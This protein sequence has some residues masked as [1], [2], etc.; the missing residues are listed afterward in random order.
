MT[1]SAALRSPWRDTVLPRKVGNCCYLSTQTNMPEFLTF[2]RRYPLC[3]RVCVLCQL[4]YRKI[5]ETR[6]A[7]VY[8]I[9]VNIERDDV[10]NIYIY[11]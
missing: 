6:E 4:K 3:K 7:Y 5:S 11:I 9:V 1:A 8:V 10:L 2:E